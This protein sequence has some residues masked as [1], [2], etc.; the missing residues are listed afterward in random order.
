MRGDEYVKILP[1]VQQLEDELRAVKGVTDV[2]NSHVT[3]KEEIQEQG[4]ARGCGSSIV[5]VAGHWHCPCERRL[6]V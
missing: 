2:E 3:G 4:Q 6:R 5:I 1:A